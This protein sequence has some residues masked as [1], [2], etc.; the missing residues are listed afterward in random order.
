MKWS[1]VTITAWRNASAEKNVISQ[2]RIGFKLDQNRLRAERNT[3]HMF[4]VIRNMIDVQSAQWKR[5][6]KSHLVAILSLS[7]NWKFHPQLYSVSALRDTFHCSSTINMKWW[8]QQPLPRSNSTCVTVKLYFQFSSSVR[9]IRNGRDPLSARVRSSL[10]SNS[11]C[12]ICCG[13][14]VQKSCTIYPQQSTTNRQQ[15]EAVRFMAFD[16]LWTYCSDVAANDRPVILWHHSID[17]SCTWWYRCIGA[18]LQRFYSSSGST[19]HNFKVWLQKITHMMLLYTP[20]WSRHD[21]FVLKNTK[22]QLLLHVSSK[23]LR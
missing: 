3:W 19:L 5:H 1:K 7:R 2:E 16:L 10:S 13:F 4:E 15:V 9:Y 17:D 21:I 6:V 11:T 12:S 8:L 14:V 20:Y 23:T 18:S 22:F